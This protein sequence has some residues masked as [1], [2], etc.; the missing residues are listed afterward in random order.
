MGAEQL[1]GVMATVG[2]GKGDTKLRDQ[3]E[4]ETDVVFGSARL[5]DDGII[6]PALT[7]SYVGMGL[8]AALGGWGERAETKFGVFRM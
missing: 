7:R 4:A 3:I 2:K 1:A 5:W 6:E 8:R